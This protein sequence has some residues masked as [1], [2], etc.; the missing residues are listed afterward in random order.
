MYLLTSGSWMGIWILFL[1]STAAVPSAHWAGA[2]RVKFA[3]DISALSESPGN[4][5]DASA[6]GFST[7]SEPALAAKGKITWDSRIKAVSFTNNPRKLASLPAA[8][9]G[10]LLAIV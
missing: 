4:D 5:K 10:W 2:G 9:G 8:W 1:Q 6:P 3:G 7:F